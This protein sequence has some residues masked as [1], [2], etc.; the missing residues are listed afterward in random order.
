MTATRRA[1]RSANANKG[2]SLPDGWLAEL[3]EL[4]LLAAEPGP[5]ELQACSHVLVLFP[6][7]RLAGDRLPAG[8]PGADRLQE[9]LKRRRKKPTALRRQPAGSGKCLWPR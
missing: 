9:A 1:P 7:D 4:K 5:R 2:T 6:A 8:L 3:P